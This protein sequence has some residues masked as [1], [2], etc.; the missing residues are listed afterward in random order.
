M[1]RATCSEVRE[2]LDDLLDD[3]LPPESRQ[4]ARVHLRECVECRQSLDRL[5]YTRRLLHNLPRDTM[6]H[7]MKQSLLEALRHRTP[8]GP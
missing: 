3:A 8:A 2:S 4:G 1:K 6:P 5:G 7:P